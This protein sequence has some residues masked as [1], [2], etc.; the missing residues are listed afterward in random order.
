MM[1]TKLG[2]VAAT[3]A[4]SFSATAPVF[5]AK[6][7]P[8]PSPN[9]PWDAPSHSWV[10]FLSGQYGDH[11]PGFSIKFSKT[12]GTLTAGHCYTVTYLGGG[13]WFASGWNGIQKKIVPYQS[14]KWRTTPD[15]YVM[16][17]WEA[18]LRYNEGGEVYNNTT[19]ELV[20]NMWCH[21]DATFSEC[22]K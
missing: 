18:P 8:N 21:I 20:G 1:S 4:A 7:L 2:L 10:G 14:V 11:Q 16:N 3:M 6:A 12:V 9:C 5:A 17:V 15:T 13:T 19:N 22:D